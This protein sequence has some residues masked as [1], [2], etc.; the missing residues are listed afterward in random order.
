MA[1]LTGTIEICDYLRL[2]ISY[3]PERVADAL[4]LLGA[5]L[6]ERCWEEETDT[7]S[8]LNLWKQ[9]LKIRDENGLHPKQ[10]VMPLHECYRNQREFE[11]LDELMALSTDVDKM[12]IQSLLIAERVLGAHHPKFVSR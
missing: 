3:S 11:T 10:P 6:A 4:E 7:S 5:T 1:C 2:V 9:A 12:T 8:S